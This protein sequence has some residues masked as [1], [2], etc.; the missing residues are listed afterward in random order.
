MAI[1]L[2]G[3]LVITGSIFATQ[4]ITGSFSGSATSASY[5]DTL[6][7]LGSASFAPAATFNT[8]SQSFATTSGSAASRLNIIETSY[9]TTGSNNFTAPQQISDVSNAISFTSTASLYTN[10][11]LRVSKDSYVSGTAY[12]NNIVVYGTSSI[13]YITSSQLDIS[14]NIIAVNTFTPAV[15]FGGLA[16]Y[17]SGS[18]GLTGS[19]LWD[20]EMNRWV[21]SN[22]S[23][24]TYDGGM[25]ISG[26]RNTS[27]LGNEQGTTSCALMMGQGGDHI[28]SSAI[29]SY[30]NATCFYGASYIS[31][32]GTACFAG[33]ITAPT[34]T[35]CSTDA[36]LTIRGTRGTG[37]THYIGAS[38]TNNDNLSVVAASGMYLTVNS[39]D[40]L[41][42]S[43]T[44]IACFACQVCANST[45][46]ISGAFRSSTFF[47]SI[48]LENTGGDCGG[49]WNVQS[50]SG[51]QVGGSAGSS[52][53]IY[54]YCASA[55]R[56]WIN[57]SGSV[58]IGTTSPTDLLELSSTSSPRVKVTNTTNSGNSGIYFNV[59]DSSGTALQGGI[60]YIPG[61][62][63]YLTLSGD[64]I[65]SHLN[66]TRAGN[67]GIGTASPSYILDV[68]GSTGRIKNSGG[69]ADF[70]LDRA[71]TSAGATSQ[72][73][74]A[75]TLKWYTGLRGL[76]NDNLYVFNNAT[77]TNTLILDSSTNAATFACNITAGG[78]IS[79]TT[80]GLNSDFS[81]GGLI[82]YSC[83]STLRYTQVGFDC[84]GNY[85]WIQALEQG[86]AYRN[87]ILNAAGG[88]VGIGTTSLSTEANL[89]LGAQ[90]TVEGGQLVLQKGTSCNCA[91]HLD[92]YQDRFRVM[93]GTNTTSASELFNISML[94]GTVSAKYMLYNSRVTERI[95][96]N[97]GNGTWSLFTN[98]SGVTQSSGTVFVEAIYGT[99]NT[100]GQWMYKIGGN[101]DVNLSWSNTTGYSGTTPSLTWY[102]DTLCVANTNPSV[103]FSVTVRL[104]NIG[105]GWAETWGNLPGLT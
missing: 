84:I 24:S 91:T 87:L 80:T 17:D 5:A 7:G 57:S 6:Q 79:G 61:S 9:A 41:V 46:G 28:T 43:S 99:P 94:N 70:I 100:T 1:A 83:G 65:N 37:G 10:G 21:Y 73:V 47:G 58:G 50:V 23:G 30:G 8:V 26:P 32:S 81:S 55:Y 44:G 74:T 60:Y 62:T 4:G 78:R 104:N 76:A 72:Y 3:S 101:R 42:I 56:L 13:Q 82:A 16:V 75:G 97:N 105:N 98:G 102:T 39:S 49:K 45:G 14:D 40:R 38:G 36:C 11:G 12:F 77:S 66:V 27:G 68:S 93:A 69:S 86:V 90:S 2:S 22:P 85:G 63:T 25:I 96:G 103:Y 19:M 29:F 53:G 51:T 31:S 35:V 89:Y 67:V 64:N 48:D 95:G 71:S 59:K 15:R 18:T 34:S 92:N 54:S 52:F 88:N 33:N 20:S